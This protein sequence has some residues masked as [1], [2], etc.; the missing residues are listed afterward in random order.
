MADRFIPEPHFKAPCTWLTATGFALGKLIKLI[1]A[2]DWTLVRDGGLMCTLKL[3]DWDVEIER[4]SVRR[5]VWPSVFKT[6][7]RA[8]MRFE[9]GVGRWPIPQF[10]VQRSEWGLEQRSV[11]GMVQYPEVDKFWLR[12]GTS[13]CVMGCA[14][15]RVV[16]SVTRA[17][18]RFGCWVV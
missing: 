12:D 8:M 17:W 13:A 10:V 7:L 18:T 14:V 15:V 3:Q 11:F 2:G 4:Q 5:A 1:W 16:D 9:W 6:A